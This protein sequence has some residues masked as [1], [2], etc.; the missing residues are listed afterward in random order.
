MSGKL[1]FSIE[2]L[3][4]VDN[5]REDIDEEADLRSIRGRQHGA[6]CQISFSLNSSV[7]CSQY[8]CWFC[9]PPNERP[10]W[11]PHC[12]WKCNILSRAHEVPH[13]LV[14]TSLFHFIFCYSRHRRFQIL[15][16]LGFVHLDLSAWKILLPIFHMEDSDS[17]FNTW[18]KCH[19]IFEPF[20][21]P[22]ALC[23]S[24]SLVLQLEVIHSYFCLSILH[25]NS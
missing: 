23:R 15:S 19:L 24:P 6:S 5:K 4:P 14:L 21:T 10:L 25:C 9:Q 12:Q 20:V 1:I 17:S 2:Y 3:L 18:L 13:P 16:R 22:Q 8:Q 11:V 7:S